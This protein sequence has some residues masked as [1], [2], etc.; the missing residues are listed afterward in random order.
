ME[1]SLIFT[2]RCESTRQGNK[3]NGGFLSIEAVDEADA[4]KKGKNKIE[5]LFAQ[6]GYKERYLSTTVFRPSDQE[7]AR[8]ALNEF[9]YYDGDPRLWPFYT[10][11]LRFPEL[12]FIYW[13]YYLYIY[14]YK[15][16]T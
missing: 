3:G 13:L 2:L 10:Y 7:K 14:K 9:I 12:F 16:K 5:A 11:P 6:K 15:H 8:K 4:L 1:Q